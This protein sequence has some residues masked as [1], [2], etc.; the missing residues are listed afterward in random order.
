M[1]SM[2]EVLKNLLLVSSVFLF[3]TSCKVGL[4]EAVD[5]QAPVISVQTPEILSSVSESFR[6]SGTASDNIG[7]TS[8]VVKIT[9]TNQEYKYNGSEWQ[10]KIGEEWESYS[11]AGVEGNACE[12]NWFVVVKIENAESAKDYTIESQVYDAFDNSGK[13]SKDSRTITADIVPPQVSIISPTLTT[14]YESA[15]NKKENYQLKDS[16]VITSLLNQSLVISGS[17][18]EDTKLDAL[19]LYLDEGVEEVVVDS[20]DVQDLDSSINSFFST[21]VTGESLYNWE[22]KLN[23][24]DF[25]ES[26]STGKHLVRVITESFDTAGNVERKVQGWFI[27]WNEADK[28]WSEAKFGDDSFIQNTDSAAGPVQTKVYPSCYLQGQSYDDDGL[29]EVSVKVVVF[30]TVANLWDEDNATVTVTDLTDKEYPTYYAWSVRA[31]SENK[32][33]KVVVNCKDKNGVVG[34]TVIRYLGISDVTPP[35]LIITN[36]DNGSTVLGDSSGNFTIKGTL[37]DDGDGVTLKMVRIANNQRTAILD[38]FNSEYE[39]WSNDVNGNKLFNINIVDTGYSGGYYSWS[40]EKSFNIF[41]DFGIS[42][43]EI[44]NTQYFIF[45][46]KDSNGAGTIEPL[47]LQGDT[48]APSLSITKLSVYNKNNDWLKDYDLTL[49]DIQTINPYTKESAVITDKV[50]IS[51]TWGDNTYRV[52]NDI[53]KISKISF[54]IFNQNVDITPLSD[55]TWTSGYITP[56]E[57]TTANISASITDLGGNTTKKT[58]S[59]YVNSSNPELV[60]ISSLNSDGSYGSGT[61]ALTME[62]NKKVTFTGPG[63]ILTLNNGGT[64]VYDTS[65]N[66]NGS[67][68]HYYKY[69]VGNSDVSKLEVTSISA[70]NSS[71]V[72]SDNASLL[73]PTQLPYSGSRLAD[74]RSI[75]IDRTNPTVASI[76]AITASGSY[77]TNK[78]IFIQM[79]FSE[80]VSFSNESSIKLNFTNGKSTTSVTKNGSQD[81]LF[82]YKILAGDEALDSN[83]KISSIDFGTSVIKDKAENILTVPTI[84]NANNISAAG[85]KIDTEVPQTPVAVVKVGANELTSGHTVYSEDGIKIDFNNMESTASGTIRK[86]SVDN[87]VSWSDYTGEYSISTNGVY[88]II[89]KQEDLAGNKSLESDKFTVTVDKGALLNSITSKSVDGSYA[90]GKIE[91]VLSFRRSVTLTESRLKLNVTNSTNTTR[92]AEYKSGDGT[93]EITYEYTIVAGDSCEL[94]DVTEFVATSATIGLDDVKNYITLPNSSSGMRLQDNRKLSIVTLKPVLQSAEIKTETSKTKLYLTYN[95]NI[96]KNSGDIVITQDE[97]TYKAPAV[98]S[99]TLYNEYKD[100]SYI[101]DNYI[102]GTNGAT[103]NA[104]KTKISADLTTKYVLQYDLSTDS[105]AIK[106]A[107]KSVGALTITIPVMSTAVEC[108]GKKLIITL[109]GAYS[110]PVKGATY[111]I[112]IDENTVI[113]DVGLLNEA[114][115]KAGTAAKT[116]DMPGVETPIIRIQNDKE[117]LNTSSKLVTQPLTAKFKIDCQTPSANIYYYKTADNDAKQAKHTYTSAECTDSTVYAGKGSQSIGSEV[118]KSS[119]LYSSEQTLGSASDSQNG[120]KY[121]IRAK[122]YVGNSSSTEEGYALANR[123]VII[124]NDTKNGTYDY[125]WI[126]GGDAVSGGVSTSGLPFTWD[127][128]DFEMIRGMTNSN[129]DVPTDM[130]DANKWYFVSWNISTTVYPGFLSGD[131]PSEAEKDKGPSKWCWG[132]CSWVNTKDHTPIYPGESF[133][134]NTSVSVN[135]DFGYQDKHK[136]YR[137]S[138]GKVKTGSPS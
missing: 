18:K 135:D 31:I 69:T 110:L 134:F 104:E 114:E 6:V 72:D 67:A 68:K 13:T 41:S 90:S 8:I 125:R 63:A 3:A 66:T 124:Y 78:E 103:I 5:T 131:F 44:I 35:T 115:P 119:T 122:A 133:Q 61:I 45:L 137:D 42:A 70:N 9:E 129:T 55:G 64:A 26:F 59:Y 80:S 102:E 81:L 25:P 10:R 97:N 71:W 57:I 108:S 127:S 54:N 32:L 91:I 33:F 28:P 132:S 19:Y 118:T 24:S 56:L 49:E 48:E 107:F 79:H 123:T 2:K 89:A 87:G 14:S 16:N 117:T 74:L 99:S 82:K 29:S 130:N 53:N 83:L 106:N 38:Y 30:N 11:A 23:T 86:F 126:R 76:T 92:Y 113:N 116:I 4:G 98:L 93:S 109:D 17:Q 95:T 43:D 60:R 100:N 77:T 46:A 36:P 128:S 136:E 62:Y 94:L 15:A 65:S 39:G 58:A 40:F 7:I 96:S 75:C 1:K 105:T 101:K 37:T 21:Q 112:L 121:V 85:I 111:S 50:V 27:Y 52:W 84:T 51:G 22:V 12:L 73:D 20:L 138:S 120:Y 88:E 34:D 47:S